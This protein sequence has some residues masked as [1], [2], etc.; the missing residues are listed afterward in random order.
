MKGFEVISALK[1]H[2]NENVLVVG[3]TG[4]ISREVYHHLPRPQVYLRGSMGL[5]VPVG[6]GLAL[7]NPTRNVIIITGDGSFLMGLGS[8]TT[9][10]FYK[11][12][13]LKILILD[14]Q[15]YFT[16]GGQETVSSVL[17]YSK[18]LGS[19]QLQPNNSKIASQ[20]QIDLTLEEFLNNESFNILHLLI[21]EGKEDLENIPWHPE[22]ITTRFKDKLEIE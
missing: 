20:E 10:A 8:A 12:K 13:N 6:L 22:E 14:N 3:S 2:I 11:P 7:S 19:L 9:A 4:N 5:A 15:K 1:K 17:D 18:L 16:T 21:N